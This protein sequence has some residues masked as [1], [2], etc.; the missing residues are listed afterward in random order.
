MEWVDNPN[1]IYNDKFCIV[2]GGDGGGG[3]TYYCDFEF[4]A[5]SFVMI[6][7][8]Q[9]SYKYLADKYARFYL[10]VAISERLYQTIQHGR[11]ISEIPSD[12]EIKLPITSD[13]QIDFVYMSNYMKSLPYAEL[14]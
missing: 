3:K 14:L 4:G 2:S 12:I 7:D 6:C 13:G 1:K 10:A 5:T 9:K 8:L 11:T